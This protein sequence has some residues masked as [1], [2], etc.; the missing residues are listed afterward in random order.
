MLTSAELHA[1][2]RNDVKPIRSVRK[3]ILV[4]GYGYLPVSV[5]IHVVQ[6]ST[7]ELLTL[8]GITHG[9]MTLRSAA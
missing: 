5:P 3:A 6:P 7:L 1:M 9:P 2:N 4:S 8:T